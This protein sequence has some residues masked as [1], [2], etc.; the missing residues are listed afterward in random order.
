MNRTESPTTSHTIEGASAHQRSRATEI[1]LGVFSLLIKDSLG[2]T[3]N[4]NDAKTSRR[5]RLAHSVAT[6]EAVGPLGMDQGLVIV[7]RALRDS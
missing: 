3:T 1:N 7:H 2:S 6:A 4:D 5:P